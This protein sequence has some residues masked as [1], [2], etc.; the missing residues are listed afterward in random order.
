MT[1]LDDA[2]GALTLVTLFLLYAYTDVS[3][4]DAWLVSVLP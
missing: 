4:V 2:L 1:K 3:A